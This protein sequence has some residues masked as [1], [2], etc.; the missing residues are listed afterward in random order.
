[1]P[2]WSRWAWHI[3]CPILFTLPPNWVWLIT[4]P[5]TNAEHSLMNGNPIE[6]AYRKSFAFLKRNLNS[7]EHSLKSNYLITFMTGLPKGSAGPRRESGFNLVELLV[8]IAI[9]ALLAALLLPVLGG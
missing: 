8:V 4:S 3:G 7:R 2:N 9:I 1:M 6:I 5:K